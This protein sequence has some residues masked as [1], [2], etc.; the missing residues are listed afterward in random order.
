MKADDTFDASDRESLHVFL[1]LDEHHGV[2]WDSTAAKTLG[3]LVALTGTVRDSPRLINP[4]PAHQN[5]AFTVEIPLAFFIQP[6]VSPTEMHFKSSNLLA[7]VHANSG[8][9]DVA[10]VLTLQPGDYVRVYVLPFDLRDD[11]DVP[12]RT[13]DVGLVGM[14]VLRRVDGQ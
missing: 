2:R 8:N 13:V 10:N 12:A 5:Y 11:P 7:T 1:A 6:T 14:T 4:T 3:L 9:F